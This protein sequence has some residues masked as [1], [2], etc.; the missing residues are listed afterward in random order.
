M[1]IYLNGKICTSLEWRWG[2]VIDWE[3]KIGSQVWMD[4]WCRKS[5][6]FYHCVKYNFILVK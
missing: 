6:L 4:E 3:T 5:P 1:M 2:F